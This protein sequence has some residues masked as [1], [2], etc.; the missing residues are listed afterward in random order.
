MI[1]L[2]CLAIFLTLLPAAASPRPQRDYPEVERPKPKPK[3]PK[4]VRP[5]GPRVAE[6]RANGVL[7]VLTDPPKASVLIKSGSVT[8]KKGVSGEGQFRA[9]LPPGLYRV[10]VTSA[11]YKPFT[12]SASVKQVG[13][14]PVQADLTPTT[15]SILIGLGSLDTDVTILVDGKEPVKAVKVSENQVEIQ[16]VETGQ[17]SVRISHASIVDW[18]KKVEVEG[19]AT[20]T[21]TPRFVASIVNLII[22][23]EPGAEVFVDNNYEGRVAENGELR[24][25]NIKPGERSI[26]VV[27]DKFEPVTLTRRFAP[28]GESLN[29]AMKRVVFSEPFAD[30]FLGGSAL[31]D[32]P[33]SWQVT[34]GKMLVRSTTPGLSIG[35]VKG[36]DYADFTME[37]DVSFSNGKGAVWIVRARD[38]QNFYLFQLIGPKGTGRNTFHSFVY[39]GG[40]LRQL[41]PPE[42]LALDLSR[43]GDSFHI[44]VELRGPSI[45]HFIEVS[46]APNAAGRQ[47]LSV[48]S[49]NTFSHGAV[50]FGVKDNEEFLVYFVN[51]TPAR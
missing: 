21:V 4:P 44:T 46:S 9:E 3:A 49:D 15:G 38:S 2:I 43:P 19:G 47:P 13:T 14:E 16:G 29:L 30:S 32:L 24:I 22:K 40:Q 37:F 50:G 18:E 11:G 45:K 51:I 27:K 48:L 26:R 42:F 12:A 41:K 8:V 25:T 7:F 36:N 35:M 31:W 17:H 28:G 20:T 39:Q 23:S 10:E 33:K 6:N 5:R 34:T 1:R